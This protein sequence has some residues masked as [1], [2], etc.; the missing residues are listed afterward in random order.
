MTREIFI[1]LEAIISL[2]SSWGEK[3]K[4]I[5]DQVA[6]VS[7]LTRTQGEIETKNCLMFLLDIY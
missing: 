3:N 5:L 4:I 2:K 7:K 6:D 1:K